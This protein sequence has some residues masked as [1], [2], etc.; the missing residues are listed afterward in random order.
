MCLY[1]NRYKVY[2]LFAAKYNNWGGKIL[3]PFVTMFLGGIDTPGSIFILH[4]IVN[5]SFYSVC[6]WLSNQC[7]EIINWYIT[8][9][10]DDLTASICPPCDNVGEERG[11]AFS[12]S[13]DKKIAEFRTKTPPP[14]TILVCGWFQ[15]YNCITYNYVNLNTIHAL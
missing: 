4:N 7:Y 9:Y 3:S 10:L 15:R 1:S 14:L 13:I 5:F 2:K 11:L 8:V 6:Y 12:P